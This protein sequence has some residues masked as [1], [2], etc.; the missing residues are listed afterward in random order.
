[1]TAAHRDG[2]YRRAHRSLRE[3]ATVAAIIE[4]VLTD[5]LLKEQERL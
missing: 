5:R 3:G 1:M 4:I 2:H